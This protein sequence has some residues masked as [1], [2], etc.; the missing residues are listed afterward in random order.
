MVMFPHLFAP[1]PRAPNSEPVFNLILL[2]DDEAQKDPLYIA[3]KQAVA[4]AVDAQFGTGKSRDVNWL[5][6]TKFRSPFRDAMEKSKFTG[7]NAG[8]TFIN[9]WTKSKPGVVDPGAAG[10]RPNPIHAPGDVWAGQLGRVT[11]NPYVYNTAGNIGCSLMLDNVQIVKLDMPRM[12]GRQSAESAFDPWLEDGAE[13][14]SA[15]D[16]PF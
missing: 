3:L 12:D 10:R 7:F 6:Q 8:M 13:V 14:A 4:Q 16:I 15:D 11:V 5:K 1:R 2:F 9:P